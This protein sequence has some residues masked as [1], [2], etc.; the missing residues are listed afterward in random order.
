MTGPSFGGVSPAL[1]TDLYEL[2][3]AAAYHAHGRTGSATFEV[4][5]RSLPPRRNFLV[6]CGLEDLLAGLSIWRFGDAEI[7]YLRSLGQFQEDFLRCVAGLQFSGDLRA[8]HEGEV[9]FAGEP[10]VE[11]TA[12]IVEAQLLE[13]L[14][15]NV[16][17]TRTMQASKAARVAIACQGRAFVDFSARRDHGVDAA[18]GAARAAAIAGADAT[19]LVEAGRRFGLPLSGTMA[20]A[21]VMAF[22]D[23][24]DAFRTFAR[25]FPNNAVLLLD[26]WDTEEG[27]RHAVEV[28]RDLRRDGIE[29]AGV[30]LDSGDFTALARKVREILDSGGFPDVR[31]VASGDLD[32]DRIAALVADDAP[33]DGFGVGTRMGTSEDAPSLGVVYK[34][35]EDEHGPKLKLAESKSTLPGRKQILRRDGYDTLGLE[36][37]GGD[38]RPLL[39]PVMKSGRRLADPEPIGDLRARCATAIGALP[40]DLRSLGPADSPYEVR[41]SAGLRALVDELTA[42]HRHG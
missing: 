13:T 23:E 2:T 31:I 24:R 21:Y 39:Q 26:T 22:D 40:D 36:A 27:A 37:E 30:R 25:T 7:E 41:L 5:V 11:I 12:P 1:F 38:G 34:L 18:L 4:F 20:H 10:I 28:A 14:A 19:S 9:V 32:E 15:L 8:V 33:I 35:V 3:M 6:A 17:G 16:I 29:L 42:A